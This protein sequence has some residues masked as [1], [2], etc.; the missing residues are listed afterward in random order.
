MWPTD[1]SVNHKYATH[2]ILH[3]SML[4][5]YKKKGEC[6]NCTIHIIVHNVVY[7][8]LYPCIQ[9]TIR[10]LKQ[11]LYCSQQCRMYHLSSTTLSIWAVTLWH[12]SHFYHCTVQR[13]EKSGKEAEKVTGR[14]KDWPKGTKIVREGMKEKQNTRKKMILMKYEEEIEIDQ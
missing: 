12:L 7:C 11:Q 2:A 14:R 8:I 5:R 9:T 1:H 10:I 4:R 13:G 3:I 6:T